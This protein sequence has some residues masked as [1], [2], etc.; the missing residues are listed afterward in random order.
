[1]RFD[2]LGLLGAFLDVLGRVKVSG[3]AASD[4]DEGFCVHRCGLLG[5]CGVREGM[6]RAGVRLWKLCSMTAKGL[7]CRFSGVSGLARNV[8]LQG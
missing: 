1:M 8:Q 6:G 2:V 4:F 7:S 3:T 5:E